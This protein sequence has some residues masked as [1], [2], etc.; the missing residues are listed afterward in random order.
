MEDSCIFF[1]L[2]PEEEHPLLWAPVLRTIRLDE[3]N[4]WISQIS[5]AKTFCS[6][7]IYYAA[8]SSGFIF[9]LSLSFSLPIRFLAPHALTPLLYAKRRISW[10]NCAPQKRMNNNN[11]RGLLKKIRSVIMSDPEIEC[12]IQRKKKWGSCKISRN[13]QR[14]FRIFF[15]TPPLFFF[16]SVESILM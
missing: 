14:F 7:D 15:S 11:R 10:W 9:S 1:R 2:P 5:G 13:I 6:T 8:R 12:G 4:R 3:V 16:A